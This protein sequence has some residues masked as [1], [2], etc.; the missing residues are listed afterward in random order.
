VLFV[1]LVAVE[2]ASKPTAVLKRLPVV[3]RLAPALRPK[4][5]EKVVSLKFMSPATWR[6]LLGVVVPM[7][8]LPVEL[9]V[10][11]SVPPVV[12]PRASE[13]ELNIPVLVSLAKEILGVLAEPFIMRLPLLSIE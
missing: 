8:T 6:R 13:D 3:T 4:E 7:P 5:V 10:N 2:R 12:K 9:I 1:L 11:R